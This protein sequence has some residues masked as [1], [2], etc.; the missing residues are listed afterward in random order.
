MYVNNNL[1]FV[2]NLVTE[3]Y[4]QQEVIAYVLCGKLECF[5]QPIR[6][7]ICHPSR[8]FHRKY[9]PG[10]DLY[11]PPSASSSCISLLSF[12]PPFSSQNPIVQFTT[13][14]LVILSA[15]LLP[16]MNSERKLKVFS[17]LLY[18]PQ[19]TNYRLSQEF[20]YM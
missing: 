19:V 16:V 15:L 18:P 2:G 14:S 12:P 8:S 6:L 13:I 11:S 1:Y 7:W 10:S 5:N 3:I 4:F 17:K 20:E 9:I